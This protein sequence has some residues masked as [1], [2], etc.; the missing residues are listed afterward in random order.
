MRP[1]LQALCMAVLVSACGW[2]LDLRN[3]DSLTDQSGATFRWDCSRDNDCYLSPAPSCTS[4]NDNPAVNWAAGRFFHI[5]PSCSGPSSWASSDVRF[6]ICRS[7]SDCPQLIQYRDGPTYECRAGF[8]Q[9]ND[10][11]RFA[12]YAPEQLP[13]RH[14]MY[15]LCF[16]ATPR[17]QNP[18]I[19]PPP[20]LVV[21]VEQA[22]PR[23]ESGVP[24]ERLPD[25]CPDPRTPR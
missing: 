18:T 21:Q 14:E 1:S 22:C 6:A 3:P 10:Y 25:G 16:G 20:E 13:S 15:T 17:A 11:D 23:D 4:S 24:C 8:C 2:A 7:D 9:H 12:T 19:W 5:A